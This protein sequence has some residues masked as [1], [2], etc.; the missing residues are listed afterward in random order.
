MA[1]VYYVGSADN[2]IFSLSFIKKFVYVVIN[3]RVD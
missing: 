3:I 2:R 1:Y